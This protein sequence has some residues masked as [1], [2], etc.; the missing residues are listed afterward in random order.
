MGK[1]RLR[2]ANGT[3]DAAVTDQLPAQLGRDGSQKLVAI[4]WA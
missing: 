2:R 1:F 3:M 4:E